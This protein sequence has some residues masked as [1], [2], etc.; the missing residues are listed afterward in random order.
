MTNEGYTEYRVVDLLTNDPV[1]MP[2][3]FPDVIV[4]YVPCPFHLQVFKHNL[5]HIIVSHGEAVHRTS[6][7]K[8]RVQDVFP[9]ATAEDRE[10]V[11]TG[12]C[13]KCWETTVKKEVD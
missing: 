10:V 7:K 3:Q 1:D 11:L 9:N 2:A 4:A 12:I 5:T 6:I 8:D 13:N